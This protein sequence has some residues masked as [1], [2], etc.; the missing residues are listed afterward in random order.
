MILPVVLTGELLLLVAAV[1]ALFVLVHAYRRSLGT[2]VMV[3]LLPFYVFFYAF[4]QFEH[5]RKG[6]VLAGFFGGL[7]AGVVLVQL[8]LTAAMTR[9]IGPDLGV[10]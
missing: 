2:G 9:T 8:G 4:S 10:P 7:V 5:R 3:T 6:W 1:C